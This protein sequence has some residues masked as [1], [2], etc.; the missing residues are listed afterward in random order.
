MRSGGTFILCLFS[1]LV[2]LQSALASHPFDY[3]AA[4]IRDLEYVIHE[5]HIDH[6]EYPVT[7][8]QGTWFEKLGL[9]FNRVTTDGR[10]PLDHYGHPL[11]FEP[12]SGANGNQVV[13]RSVGQNGID[14]QGALDDWDSRF[15]PNMGYWHKTDWPA[16]NRRAW[17]CAILALI[18]LVVIVIKIKQATARLVFASLWL[19]ILAAVVLP[20]GFDTGL[21]RSSASIDPEWISYVASTGALLL[22]IGII[23]LLLHFFSTI[24]YRRSLRITGTIPCQKCSYDLRGTIAANI[25][26]CPECGEPVPAD[27]DKDVDLT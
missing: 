13:I 6:G 7:D 2:C 19:G 26:N 27:A 22:L 20:Y 4:D 15:G 25:S 10:F 23:L 18:G 1:V 11:I 9:D 12:P 5:Y 8:N 3:Q 21:S 14:D 17:L 24:Y 16:A